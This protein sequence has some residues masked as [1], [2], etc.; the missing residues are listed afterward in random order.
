MAR[1]RSIKPEFPQSESMGRVSRDA[2]LLFVEL[3]TICDDEGRTR[4]ASRL[5]ASLLFPYDSDA[6]DLMDGWLAELESI[7]VIRRYRVDGDTYLEIPKWLKHQKIDH[8]TKSKL[9]E[10][11]E[12]SRVSA[13]TS[14]TVASDMDRDLDLDQEGIGGS[15]PAD[16]SA[17]PEASSPPVLMF[18]VVGAGE[19]H[20]PLREAQVAEWVEAYP[21]TDV[22]AECRRAL[23]WVNASPAKRK[24][25]GGMRRFLVGWL[26][27]GVDN[28]RASPGDSPPPRAVST[29]PTAEE[30][31][32]YL[33]GL[34]A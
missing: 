11:E 10:F 12:N 8:P 28:R 6:P 4:G 20:W 17:E 13:K 25:A 5:L 22:L 16:A 24:T 15:E 27:R 9:P 30:T 19:K 1:I 34:R 21:G 32:A 14:A 26:N 18:P 23:A 33:A 29:V 7:E 3:W 2:R 31:R